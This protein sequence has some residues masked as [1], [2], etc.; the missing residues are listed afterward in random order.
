MTDFVHPEIMW[1]AGFFDGEGCFYLHRNRYG[2]INISQSHP[3]VL[4]RFRDA[5][6]VGYVL[7]PYEKR[8]CQMWHYQ[9]T[10]SVE[11][12]HVV[13]LLY[14]HLGSLKRADA[15]RVFKAV[16]ET[17]DYSR[18]ADRVVLDDIY[19]MYLE[20]CSYKDIAEEHD[21]SYDSVVKYISTRK[22]REA[23]FLS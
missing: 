8:T 22:H 12:K 6:G 7:G 15:D 1:A 2:R 21:R 10:N 13:D 4:E 17:R 23:K 14:P 16:S 9:C 11:V 3:E 19:S 20:G 5:V 18:R